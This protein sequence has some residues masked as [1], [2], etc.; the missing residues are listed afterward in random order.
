MDRNCSPWG[1]EED[2]RRATV[3]RSPSMEMKILHKNISEEEILFEL[4]VEEVGETHITMMWFLYAAH[5]GYLAN[6]TKNIQ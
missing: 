5:K 4:V 3:W 6:P 1:T 2:P